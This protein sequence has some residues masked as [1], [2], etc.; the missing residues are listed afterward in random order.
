[1][2]WI[3]R[4]KL[5]E[6]L[7]APLRNLRWSWGAVSKS[8]RK[9][10]L[11][12]WEDELC[13][14]KGKKVVRLTNY[15]TSADRHGYKERLEQIELIEKGAKVY[16]VLCTAKDSSESP[17]S[18]KD[19]NREELLVGGKLIKNAGDWWLEDRGRKAIT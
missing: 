13:T 2:A 16:G 14:M 5:F 19:F 17:R 12:V 8:G 7:G 6:R 4:S 1:M 11:A 10:Y 15:R 9:V 3:S 18:L